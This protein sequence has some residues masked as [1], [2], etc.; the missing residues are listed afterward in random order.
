MEPFLRKAIQNLVREVNPAY[1]VL[2][3][4]EVEESSDGSLR[5]FQIAWYGLSAVQRCGDL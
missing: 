1:L 2:P 3:G 4:R 5:E